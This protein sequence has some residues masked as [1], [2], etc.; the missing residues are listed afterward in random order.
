METTVILFPAAAGKS[1]P[2]KWSDK[3]QEL[4]RRQAELVIS[5]LE[6][7]K[8]TES[9]GPTSPAA[10]S[11]Q[12]FYISGKKEALPACF[13]SKDSCESVT[14]KCNTR[15][16][17]VNKYATADGKED[18]G[19][20]YV[21][22]CKGTTTKQGGVVHWGGKACQK[23]DVSTPFWLFAGFTI[24]MIGLVS[25][26]IGLLFSVGEEKLPGVIGAGVSRSK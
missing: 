9:S 22:Q 23:Q 17:C 14:N 6:E 7:E 18:K 5:S 10:S 1:Q 19:V 25:G 24:V 12:V 15:G 8:P 3:N 20:C 21:C 26:A 11:D 2:S 4:R 13:T 16:D